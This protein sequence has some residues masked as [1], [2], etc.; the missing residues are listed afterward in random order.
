MPPSANTN[1]DHDASAMQYP[2]HVRLTVRTALSLQHLAH[3]RLAVRASNHIDT[4]SRLTQRTVKNLDIDLPIWTNISYLQQSSSCTSTTQPT[5]AT[6][7][8]RQAAFYH[9][10]DISYLRRSSSYFSSTSTIPATD[11]NL[12]AEDTPLTNFTPL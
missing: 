1:F 5:S 7:N 3:A 11:I 2:V 4:P 8:N 6:R 9:S 10:T 12:L